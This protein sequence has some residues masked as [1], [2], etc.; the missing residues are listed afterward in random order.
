M[1]RKELSVIILV[2]VFFI[3]LSLLLYPSISNYINKKSQSGI[4]DDYEKV[5]DELNEQDFAAYFEEAEEYNRRLSELENQFRDYDKLEGY[6]DILNVS[7][8]GVIGYITIDKIK[9]EMP[10]YHTVSSEVLN[11][12][13]GHMEGSSLPIGGSSTHSVLS[14]HR[15]LPSA[16]LFTDLDLLEKGDMFTITI[17]DRLFTYRVDQ[18]RI[19]E[20]NDAKDLFIQADKDYCTLLTC[21]PYGINTQRL[22]VRGERCENIA[23]KPALYIA[24]DAYRISPTIVTPAVAAPMLL[25]LL[26]I[27]LVKYRKKK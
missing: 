17:L 10:I 3:G 4:V 11:R 18:I 1:K 26:V 14:A 13:A 23:E 9:V 5:L 25:V 16:R 21:T 27:L 15:G 8:S 2:I 12:A 7:G 24:N 22:L 20:P 19:V 6:A